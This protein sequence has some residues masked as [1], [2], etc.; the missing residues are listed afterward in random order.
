MK[1]DEKIAVRSCT[2]KSISLLFV[3]FLYDFHNCFVY[4]TNLVRVILFSIFSN[5]RELYM[6]HMAYEQ[7][8]YLI[9]RLF[10][11]LWLALLYY[12]CPNSQQL[13]KQF[14]HCCWNCTK[15]GTTGIE[16]GPN[17]DAWISR[18]WLLFLIPSCH[19][20]WSQYLVLS[21]YSSFLFKMLWRSL[22]YHFSCT[23]KSIVCTVQFSVQNFQF[24]LEKLPHVSFMFS[25]DM[26][27]EITNINLIIY[28]TH[29]QTG[30]YLN[31]FLYHQ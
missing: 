22:F 17:F 20:T 3:Q 12:V 2:S 13:K 26:D 27:K 8:G 1:V 21:N 4:E 24:V 19:F 10:L 30:I 16:T 15:R 11:R 14:C 18:V 31:I 5:L 23:F 7:V 6:I 28:F 29:F 9:L 25:L